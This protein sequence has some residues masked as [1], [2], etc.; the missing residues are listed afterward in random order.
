MSA[1]LEKGVWKDNAFLAECSFPI[2]AAHT[3]RLPFLTGFVLDRLIPGVSGIASLVKYLV[4]PVLIV[5]IIMLAYLLAKRILP[6][7]TALFTGN[8]TGLKTA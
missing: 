1:L 5:G 2:F 8:R 7:T 6:R 3:I 4:Q